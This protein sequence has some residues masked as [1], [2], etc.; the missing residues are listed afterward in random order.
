MVI[1]EVRGASAGAGGRERPDARPPA[2][3]AF[4]WRNAM[5]RWLGVVL[6]LSGMMAFVACGGEEQ[7]PPSGP[8]EQMEQAGE[9][10]KEM[11]EQMEQA[12]EETKEM[13]E[14]QM[15]EMRMSPPEK[16]GPP[17]E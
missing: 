15:R 9:Q 12:G 10:A 6:A 8:G 16:Q 3:K 4:F 14:E 2:I 17:A 11:G 13:T 7:A 5:L 1:A